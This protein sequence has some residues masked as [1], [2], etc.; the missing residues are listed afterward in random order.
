MKKLVALILAFFVTVGSASATLYPRQTQ[1]AEMKDGWYSTIDFDFSHFHRPV[2]GSPI[3][4]NDIQANRFTLPS[5]DMRYTFDEKFRVGLNIPLVYG[6]LDVGPV[7][8]S[9]FGFGKLGVTTE[10]KL[11]D[12]VTGF[13][14]QDFDTVH[15]TLLGLDS[16]GF[17]TGLEIQKEVSDK[18]TYFGE[19]G[20]RFDVPERGAVQHSFIYNNAVVWDTDSWFNPSLELIGFSNFTADFTSLQIIPGWVT[21]FGDGN[22]QFRIG[23]PIGLNPDS[24]DIG[25]SAGVYLEI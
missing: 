5:F 21:P 17:E 20:Y 23:L 6:D 19:Y 12:S 1:F 11:S 16:Y 9:A 14:N 15:N 22:N 18:L 8:S 13:I 24:P 2:S 25:V 3:G 7:E 10:M 4:G